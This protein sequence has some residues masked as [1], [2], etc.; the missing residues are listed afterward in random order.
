M[1]IT[2]L[3]TVLTLAACAGTAE[4]APPAQTQPPGPPPV[5]FE[6]LVGLATSY[7]ESG[8]PKRALEVAED[9]I[10]KEEKRPEGHLV[11]GRA[12]AAQEKLEEAIVAFERARDLGAEGHRVTIELATLYD[13]ARRYDDAIATYQVHLKNHP[14]DAEAHQQL[15]LTFLLADRP[16]EAVPSLATA[17][18]LAPETKQIAIDY[19]LALTRVGRSDDARRE[20]SAVTEADPERADAWRLLAR[21][22][23]LEG[24]W[25]DAI[26][27]VDRALALQPKDIDALALRCRLRF[28]VGRTDE[29][30]ED[31]EGV[32]VL[33][34]DNRGYTLRT[35]G[36]LSTLG[37]TEDAKRLVDDV[38][39]S[40]PDHP[41]VRFRQDQI[42]A[43]SGDKAALER[44]VE[45][46]KARPTDPEVWLEVRA[47]AKA[48]RKRK[49]EKQASDTLEKLGIT[50]R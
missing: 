6:D 27:H 38:A 13:V 8:R 31:C 16:A 10:A 25:N 11:A 44:I 49:L 39:A 17:R 43:R 34:P 46:A 28:F 47:L 18:S 14:D 5:S 29:A 20:L 22:E 3:L 1:R 23:A 42:A 33:A 45:L 21:A 40:L 19:G 41:A 48:Q 30:L 12:L 36:L 2:A 50:S 37:R 32:R 4:D 9:A 15:G 35:A 26:G 24:Q 7:L